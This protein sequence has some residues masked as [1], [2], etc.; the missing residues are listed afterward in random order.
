MKIL[1]LR[2]LYSE[3]YREYIVGSAVTGRHGVYLVYGEAAGNEKREMS[4]G[5]HDEILLLLEGE[6]V[7]ANGA[8]KIPL[9]KEQAVSLDS[10]GSFTFIAL[11]DCRYVV[12]GT[13]IV[14]HEH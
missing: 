13:H 10:D 1:N 11:T 14:P 5:G 2:E 7:L 12:A 6:A 3:K 4:P 8:G 9:R